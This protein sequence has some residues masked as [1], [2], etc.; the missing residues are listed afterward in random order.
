M[1]SQ[2]TPIAPA[3]KPSN[4]A[5]EPRVITPPRLSIRRL[6]RL[7]LFADLI[8]A[9]VALWLAALGLCITLAFRDELMPTYIRGGPR[10]W[11]A[12][13]LLAFVLASVAVLVHDRVREEFDAGRNPDL[14][15]DPR[16]GKHIGW[17]ASAI[18]LFTTQP[19]WKQVAEAWQANDPQQ[20]G[21]ALAALLAHL[22][23]TMV[24]LVLGWFAPRVVTEYRLY[25][26]N[27]QD[28][29]QPVRKDDSSTAPKQLE[30]F[31]ITALFENEPT[32]TDRRI[33]Q[34]ETTL[35]LVSRER[36]ELAEQLLTAGTVIERQDD[37]LKQ[38]RNQAGA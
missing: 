36:D 25:L 28:T 27:Q 5:A 15:A 29:E 18:G 3:D 23:P 6:Q 12:D 7:S 33:T 17:A 38:L 37:E 1:T 9:G 2:P 13:V 34:L 20:A 26:H 22:A 8:A 11:V 30:H 32:E 19:I 24:I 35:E 14:P 21:H 16:Y 10:E 4:M 31:D